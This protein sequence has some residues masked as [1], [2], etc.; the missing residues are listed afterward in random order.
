MI[1]NGTLGVHV[2]CRYRFQREHK[3]TQAGEPTACGGDVVGAS[4]GLLAAR[5]AERS[6]QSA[7]Y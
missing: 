4:D 7:E 1:E 2:H 3:V 5:V 6:T